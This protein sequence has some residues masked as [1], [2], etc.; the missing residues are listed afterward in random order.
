MLFL[1]AHCRLRVK[2]PNIPGQVENTTPDYTFLPQPNW[3]G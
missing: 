3:P 1:D 2:V